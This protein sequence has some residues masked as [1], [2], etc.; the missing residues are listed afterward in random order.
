MNSWK[1]DCTTNIVVC[2]VQPPVRFLPS[3]INVLLRCCCLCRCSHS[4]HLPL[5]LFVVRQ[6]LR[7]SSEQSLVCLARGLEWS[8]V[9][10]DSKWMDATVESQVAVRFYFHSFVLCLFSGLE[11][12]QGWLAG[13]AQ[14]WGN[15]EW[16]VLHLQMVSK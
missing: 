7:P 12:Y 14:L 5:C 2:S 16:C 10:D 8:L 1:R 13:D 4:H 11:N 3:W 15:F 6:C 9:E